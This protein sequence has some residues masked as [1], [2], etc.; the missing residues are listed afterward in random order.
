M[1]HTELVDDREGGKKGSR[2]DMGALKRSQK[3]GAQDDSV[4]PSPTSSPLHARHRGDDDSARSKSGKAPLSGGRNAAASV[5]V[6]PRQPKTTST[7]SPRKPAAA[8]SSSSANASISFAPG[9]TNAESD[10]VA[11]QKKGI[12][13]WPVRIARFDWQMP[14]N[15]N[16]ANNAKSLLSAALQLALVETTAMSKNRLYMQVG[17]GLDKNV[18]M[19]FSE[20]QEENAQQVMRHHAAYKSF[21]YK[22]GT[23][24]SSGLRDMEMASDA[25]LPHVQALVSYVPRIVVRRFVNEPHKPLRLP[26]VETYY[27]CVLFVDISG[28]TPLMEQ[29]ATLGAEGVERVT[30]HLNEYFR[31]MISLINEHG[32]DVVKFAGDALIVIWPTSGQSGLYSMALLGCQCALALQRKFGRYDVGSTQLRI[33]IGVGAGQIAGIHVGGIRGRNEFF[34]AGKPLDQVGSCEAQAEPGEVFI[35]PECQLII[36]HHFVG[37]QIGANFKLEDVDSPVSLPHTKEFPLLDTLKLRLRSYVP[38]AVLNN[39]D[40]RGDYLAELRTVSVLFVKLDYVYVNEKESPMDI[41]VYVSRMQEVIARYEGTFRQFLI[42]DKGSVLIAAFGVPPYAHEDDPMRAVECALDIARSLKTL[43]VSGSIGVTT[44]KAFCGAVGSESRREYAMVGDVVNL[45]ARLMVAAIEKGGI[46]CD[47]PTYLSTQKQVEYQVLDPIKVKG[48]D[49]PIAIYHPKRISIPTVQSTL[50]NRSTFPLQPSGGSHIGVPHNNSSTGLASSLFLSASGTT[51]AGDKTLNSDDSSS[52]LTATPSVTIVGQS[53]VLAVF[54]YKLDQLTSYEQSPGHV[55]V[56]EGEAGIGKSKLAEKLVEMTDRKRD[57][58]LGTLECG[59]TQ[60]MF[61]PW[62][63]VVDSVL[64]TADQFESDEQLHSYVIDSVTNIAQLYPPPDLIPSWDSIA[65]L[66]NVILPRLDLP[67]TE[68]TRNMSEQAQIEVLQV[69]LLRLLQT[70]V[71]PGSIIILE[72]AH[73]FDSA[74]WTLALACAQQLRGV[75]ILVCMHPPRRPVPFEYRQ[76]MHCEH[77]TY[78]SIKPLS[79]DESV[80]VAQLF[81]GVTTKLP[82]ALETVIKEKGQGNPFIIEQIL[83]SMNMPGDLVVEDGK[84]ILVKGNNAKLK[85]VGTVESLITTRIDRLADASV[86]DVLKRASVIGKNFDYTLIKHLMP[87]LSKPDLLK[88]LLD[89][90]RAG[91]IIREENAATI[92]DSE[93]SGGGSGGNG[94]NNNNTSSVDLRK[95]FR[96]RVGSASMPHRPSISLSASRRGTGTESDDI[97]PSTYLV[98][99]R[100]HSNLNAQREGGKPGSSKINFGATASKKDTPRGV[101]DKS[102]KEKEKEKDKTKEKEKNAKNE[103]ESAPPSSGRIRG[104]P[105]RESSPRAVSPSPKSGPASPKGAPNS[106]KMTSEKQQPKSSHSSP[107]PMNIVIPSPDSPRSGSGDDEPSSPRSR[108]RAQIA[109]N[110]IKAKEKSGAAPSSST[111]THAAP[112]TSASTSSNYNTA[113]EHLSS[114]GSPPEVRKEPQTNSSKIKTPRGGNGGGG[115]S[116]S[117]T[118]R[119]KGG[120]ANNTPRGVGETKE[121]TNQNTAK[122]TSSGSPSGDDVSPRNRITASG[123]ALPSSPR[124]I[125]GGQVDTPRRT[126]KRGLSMRGTSRSLTLRKMSLGSADGTPRGGTD[127]ISEDGVLNIEASEWSFRNG[128]TRDVVYGLMLVSQREK[129]HQE[130]AQWY[131]S[132]FHET[133]SQHAAV[134]G[135]HLKKS[136]QYS[137]SAKWFAIAGQKALRNYLNQEAVSFFLE[138]IQLQQDAAKKKGAGFGPLAAAISSVATSTSYVA[139]KMVT[140]VTGG[141]SS[142]SNAS[143]TASAASSSSQSSSNAKGKSKDGKKGSQNANTTAEQSNKS[144]TVPQVQLTSPRSGLSGASPPGSTEMDEDFSLLTTYRRLGQAYFN[145]GDFTNA[146]L[147]LSACL[148]LVDVNVSTAPSKSKILTPEEIQKYFRTVIDSDAYTQREV[149]LALLTM[150]KI[151]PYEGSKKKIVFC[152]SGALGI[153]LHANFWAEL[154]EAY[155]QC[156]VTAGICDQHPLVTTYTQEGRKLARDHQGLSTVIAINSGL[157]NF[158]RCAWKLAKQCFE[159]S[160][161]TAHSNSSDRRRYDDIVIYLNQI[162]LLRGKT[163]QT[164]VKLKPALE[165][166]RL[167]G[168]VQCQILALIVQITAHVQLRNFEKA[169]SKLDQVRIMLSRDN[170]TISSSLLVGAAED[171]AS[172]PSLQSNAASS[173]VLSHSST[174]VS[175]LN[176]SSGSVPSSGTKNSETSPNP[177]NSAASTTAKTNAK[178]LRSGDLS[179]EFNYHTLHALIC[180][181][182]GDILACVDA[183]KLAEDLMYKRGM[184]PV[185]F[186]TYPGY[187]GIPEIYLRLLSLPK[188]SKRIETSRRKLMKRFKKALDQLRDFSVTFRF[189]APRYHLL[190]GLGWLLEGDEPSAVVMREWERGQNLAR[191]FKMAGEE[192]LIQ[193]HIESERGT[194][195]N[196]ND[197]NSSSINSDS[198]LLTRSGGGKRAS[199]ERTEKREGKRSSAERSG[200]KRH[201]GK[202]TSA[203]RNPERKK[204][205]AKKEGTARSSS[206][207]ANDSENTPTF[208]PDEFPPTPRSGDEGMISPASSSLAL[209]SQADTSDSESRSISS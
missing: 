131:L 116:A 93:E 154:A 175:S 91:F 49:K 20:M 39:L 188:A 18:T 197:S 174:N 54:G 11:H 105:A 200:E 1:Q 107:R 95:S 130:I 37:Q 51:S 206:S 150:A 157:Y 9:T 166:A 125:E 50:L 118:P 23:M 128:T 160:M 119:G 40:T 162:R 101:G 52:D 187:M 142:S 138:A 61:G 161:V 77:A 170:S 2:E 173:P 90:Q 87:H 38:N 148:R 16:I 44:G 144:K 124:R 81:L 117:S 41:Q 207:A 185:A 121:K 3:M 172:G 33:H 97:M 104:G 53:K 79:A 86:I 199:A 96:A 47:R 98:D 88:S 56:L 183:V 4:V 196:A 72:D 66:L 159:Q 113:S 22:T 204:R 35:S 74:S 181:G 76:M 106:P 129:V 6:T 17:S 127:S 123:K 73:E 163:K 83:A 201:S 177:A 7:F 108:R 102:T 14:L 193:S 141:S 5:A 167:R 12:D 171:L 78:L 19:L 100:K 145:L 48:K 110:A 57:I 186:W 99:H 31:L 58:F 84:V 126:L 62:A 136:K 43:K 202:R 178:E 27:A 94:P 85:V 132:N 21:W 13:L 164:T 168:D 114:S 198:L 69:L 153:A 60:Q 55:L 24:K 147:Q 32:G 70:Y 143:Q 25:D 180:L 82:P 71:A 80:Q 151:G 190:L 45:S 176:A 195:S 191:Q 179:S 203:E 135:H 36:D 158:S 89:L 140:G 152:N 63:F 133:L 67:P 155:A 46:L 34:I 59:G 165:S 192:Q 184:K 139:S 205:R 194:L 103:K 182:R 189:A 115:T 109:N 120:S 137:E 156:V 64:D 112:G 10:D 208:N 134:L 8:A 26:E 65:P 28:F 15:S 42:D 122:N 146:S 92:N 29:M 68:T 209:D 30:I 169:N 75:L 149:I 111:S